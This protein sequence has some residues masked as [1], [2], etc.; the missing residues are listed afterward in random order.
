MHVAEPAPSGSLIVLAGFAGEETGDMYVLA[1]SLLVNT[2][3]IV[4]CATSVSLINRDACGA[5]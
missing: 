3:S 4:E 2:G 1:L 5:F